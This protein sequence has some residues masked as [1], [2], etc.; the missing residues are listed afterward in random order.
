MKKLYTLLKSGNLTIVL[1]IFFMPL[2]LFRDIL[3]KNFGYILLA[4]TCI[5]IVNLILC[6]IDHVIKTSV[7]SLSK[8]SFLLFH[9]SLLVIA[10]GCFVTYLTYSIGYVEIAEGHRFT[11]QRQ[12]YKDWHQRFGNRG[13]TGIKIYL[14]KIILEFWKNGQIKEFKKQ[15]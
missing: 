15:F 8:I 6:L 9:F 4:F 2:I 10:A 1:L 3:G 11:D 5:L 13:G 12:N 7:F 14:E